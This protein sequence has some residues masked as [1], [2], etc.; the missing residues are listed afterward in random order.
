MKKL[1]MIVSC[2]ML[3]LIIV[4]S[5]AKDELKMDTKESSTNVHLKAPL[6]PIRY[7]VCGPQDDPPSQYPC[8]NA[9]CPDCGYNCAFEVDIVARKLEAYTEAADLLN[10]YIAEE[11]TEYFFTN[12]LDEVEILM[13]DV[14]DDSRQAIL[15]DLQDGVVSVKC[16]PV[17]DDENEQYF[18]IY[19]LYLVSTGES[20]DYN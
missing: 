15:D 5:C 2:L 8:P 12:F 10:E 1:I 18:F 19:Q 13:P 17:W 20:P 16:H 9:S 14:V 3:I 11:N 6:P 7:F 4:S